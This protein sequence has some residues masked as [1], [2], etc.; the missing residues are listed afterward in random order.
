MPRRPAHP[1]AVVA[2]LAVGVGL[3]FAFFGANAG[4]FVSLG[5]F[6][7][8][9]LAVLLLTVAA[10]LAIPPVAARL[11]TTLNRVRAAVAARRTAAS[12]TAGVASAAYLFVTARGQGRSLRPYVHDEF[13]YLIQAHQFARGHLW[14]GPHPLAP[15]FDSFQLF[16]SPVYASAYFPGTAVLYVPGVWLHLP[17]WV[18]SVA[19]AGAVAGLLFRVAAE[20]F[21]GVGAVVAV[22]LLWAD[23]QYRSCSTMVLGQMPL[24][25][26]GLVAIVAWLAWRKTDRRR[27][28]VLA[29]GV[30]ALAAVTRPVDAGCFIAPVGLAVLLRRPR[31]V[32]W[33][34]APAVPV[35]LVQLT[36]NH[37]I[38]GHWAESPFRLYADRD[39]PGTAYGFQ[40]FD[41]AARPASPLP[42]KQALYDEYVPLLREHRPATILADQFRNHGPL[43]PARLPVTLSQLTYAPFSLLIVITPVAAAG[44]TRRRAVVLAGLPLFVAGYA[45]YVFFFPHYTLAAAAA[46]IVATLAAAEQLPALAGPLAP[47]VAVGVPIVLVALAVA[48]LPQV[49]PTSGSDDLFAAPLMADVDRQLAPLGP[50]VVLFTYDPARNTHEE[51]VYNADVAWPDDATVVRAHD[52][53]PARNA[54]LFAYYAARRPARLAYRYDEATRTLFAL[55][56]VAALR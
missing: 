19:L 46:V 4:I 45:G 30:L 9:A 26:Y 31:A 43:R 33:L 35:L 2:L 15:F 32:A 21:D 23:Q 38:S 49:D 17:P 27:W 14:F 6:G 7:P 52:L 10:A 36:L 20:L 22:A 16:V 54:E 18:T 3:M 55:G 29:G 24:L 47:R 48:G 40:P 28:L 56:P 44:L 25:L 34:L 41:P 51:P 12:A 50:A 5:T 8:T 13:S 42:Q 53:G 37:G 1:L 11:S 39:Y